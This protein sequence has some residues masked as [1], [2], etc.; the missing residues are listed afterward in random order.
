MHLE[1]EVAAAAVVEEEVVAVKDMVAAEEVVAMAEAEAAADQVTV[2]VADPGMVLGTVAD[3]VMEV[4]EA[5]V[6]GMEWEEEEAEAEVQV[7]GLCPE[8]GPGMDLDTVWLC[9]EIWRWSRVNIIIIAS[10]TIID[11]NHLSFPS[12][13]MFAIDMVAFYVF[14]LS[15]K[16]PMCSICN[17]KFGFILILIYN[18]DLFCCTCVHYSNAFHICLNFI[19]I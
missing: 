6:E 15:N 11:I 4:A 9:F 8:E 3:P 5:K 7:M 13:H 19:Q 17:I 10:E 16:M 12:F 14:F 18:N 1:V 2:P